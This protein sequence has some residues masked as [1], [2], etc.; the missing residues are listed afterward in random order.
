MRKKEKKTP[1]HGFRVICDTCS[2]GK[3]FG[4]NRINAS[5]NATH[6]IR[7]YDHHVVHLVEYRIVI[8]LDHGEQQPLYGE[9][10]PY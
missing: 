5:L 6:H 8:T 1:Q 4:A 9:E 10:V 2:Y 3:D 7:R